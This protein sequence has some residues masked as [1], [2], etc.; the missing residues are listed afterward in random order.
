MIVPFGAIGRVKWRGA[1]RNNSHNR[2]GNPHMQNQISDDD[3]RG[4]GD[5]V[6]AIYHHDSHNIIHVECG[7]SCAYYAE[8]VGNLVRSIAT[9]CRV[10][11]HAV[12][13]AVEKERLRPGEA[14]G[15]N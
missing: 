7:P 8:V 12:W 4:L 2:E 6:V 10:P 14:I 1:M 15:V 11:E 3:L 5:P 13:E 9:A